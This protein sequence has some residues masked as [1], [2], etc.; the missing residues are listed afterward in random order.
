MQLAPSESSSARGAT[1]SASETLARFE[2]GAILRDLLFPDDELP[3][4]PASRRS[5]VDSFADAL[6]SLDLSP[7]PPL[8]LDAFGFGAFPFFE[9]SH[10]AKDALDMAA[11]ASPHLFAVA[12]PASSATSSPTTP[13]PTPIQTNATLNQSRS[14]TSI[15]SP[16]LMKPRKKVAKAKSTPVLSS[17]SNSTSTPP[18]VLILDHATIFAMSATANS[19]GHQGLVQTQSNI[20]ARQETIRVLYGCGSTFARSD[21][22]TRHMKKRTCRG[23]PPPSP[24]PPPQ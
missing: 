14:L 2:N 24:P 1:P 13:T 4:F 20:I 3:L 16:I 23:A 19:S 11:F 12:D 6:R 17:S 21:A 18:T 7:P 5:S 10:S 22:V 8:P 9:L 15:L